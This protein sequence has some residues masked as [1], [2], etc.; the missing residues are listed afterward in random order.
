MEPTQTD[1]F[2]EQENETNDSQNMQK[3]SSNTA[4]EDS[5]WGRFIPWFLSITC[6]AVLAV[7]GNFLIENVEWFK[8][9]AY[10]IELI[11]AQ[12]PVYRIH[13]Y[14]MH[15]SMI[16]NSV[17]IFS[18]FA[19]MFLGLGVAFYSLKKQTNLDLQS[20]VW[21]ASVATASPG[22]IALLVGGTI[23]MYCVG[24]KS[25]FPPF[26]IIFEQ[27]AK[28]VYPENGESSDFSIEQDEE[29]PIIDSPFESSEVSLDSLEAALEIAH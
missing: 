17:G 5:T 2:S 27:G 13:T 24:N 22:I 4:L 19:I 14:H 21:S 15:M 18:G 9:T 11:N 7:I 20:K 23:I 16:K 10:E 29:L 6:I 25:D 28:V 3:V 1:P 26:P 12:E 8:R